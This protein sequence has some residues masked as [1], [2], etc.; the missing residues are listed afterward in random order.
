LLKITL[1]ERGL[2]MF[3]KSV[4]VVQSEKAVK[5]VASCAS[6]NLLSIHFIIT[7]LRST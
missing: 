6:A 2:E 1:V 7:H 4:V 3:E 5:K